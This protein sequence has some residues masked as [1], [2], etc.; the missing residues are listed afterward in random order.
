ME[1]QEEGGGSPEKRE[2]E[3]MKGGGGGGGGDERASLLPLCGSWRFGREVVHHSGD[4]W[5]LLNLAHHLQHHLQG[6]SRVSW[7]RSLACF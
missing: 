6:N 5:D 4:A 3:K 1:Q 7:S 2:R